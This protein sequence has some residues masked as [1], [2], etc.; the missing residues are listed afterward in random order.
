M[1]S[2]AEVIRSGNHL[3]LRHRANR[4]GVNPRPLPDIIIFFGIKTKDNLWR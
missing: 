4:L 2:L 1:I 3:V